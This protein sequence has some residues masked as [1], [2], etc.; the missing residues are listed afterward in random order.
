[1]KSKAKLRYSPQLIGETSEKWWLIADC[2]PEIGRY[3]RHIYSIQ[4]HRAVE[5][6]RPSWKEHIT[7][8]RNEEPPNQEP[9]LK[10]DGMEVEFDY[11]P[12]LVTTEDSEYFWLEVNC[13][14][15][16][17]IRQELGLG[18]PLWPF[19]LSIGHGRS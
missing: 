15:F 17:Q 6:I 9:W 16:T 2:D 18:D 3:Y 4:H 8:I 13:P 19:H 7:V 11:T 14:F 10:Y 12:E 1:M 5:L